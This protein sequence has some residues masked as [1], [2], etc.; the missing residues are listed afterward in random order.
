MGRD[1]S[2]AEGATDSPAASHAFVKTGT[3][4]SQDLLNDRIFLTPHTLAS[5][6]DTADGRR[7]AFSPFRNH[8][9]VE[10]IEGVAEVGGQLGNLAA[11]IQ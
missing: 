4:A 1:G 3:V 11:L 2:V 8:A 9:S 7:L 10:D 5:Y 6:I